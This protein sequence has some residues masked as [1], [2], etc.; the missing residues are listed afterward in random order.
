[1]AFHE[2]VQQRVLDV[3]GMTGAAY[4]RNEELPG[5]VAIGYLF[6][7]GLRTNAL[8]L[9]VRGSGDGGA[10][11]GVDDIDRLW[12]AFAAGAIVP[13]PWVAAMSTPRSTTHSG[14][15]H[16][17]LGMWIDAATGWWEMEGYDAGVSF[18]SVHDP[19]SGRTR[20]VVSNW[21]D[22]AWPMCKVLERHRA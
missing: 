2:L 19:A 11:A 1:L 17:G 16:Y 9:P 5:D 13:E 12:T 4:L 6:A 14:A 15:A 8:H 18:R 21:S 22:G 20:T 7:D 3:A 10:Q